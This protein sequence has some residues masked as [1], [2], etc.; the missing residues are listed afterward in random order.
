MSLDSRFLI[1]D[2]VFTRYTVVLDIQEQ[3]TEAYCDECDCR[4]FSLNGDHL[5]TN[6]QVELFD[7]IVF[8]HDEQLHGRHVEIA[9][10]ED[11]LIERFK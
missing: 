8:A 2:D 10:I 11:L 3:V 6:T 1:I 4:V 5:S 9:D 7:K